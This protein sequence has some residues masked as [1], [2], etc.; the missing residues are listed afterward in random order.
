MPTHQLLEIIM[1]LCFGCSW[2]NNIATTLK[3][4][5]H[6]GK[7]LIFLILVDIGYLCGIAAKFVSGSFHWYVV[8]FYV[9]NFCMVT[10]D[11]IL[12]FYFKNKNKTT[13]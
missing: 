8:F 12:Y 2:P 11:M 13:A 7:S 4:K 10:T 6:K 9:L 1:L 3:N 5:S